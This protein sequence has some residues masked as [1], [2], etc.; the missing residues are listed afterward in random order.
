VSAGLV[1]RALH[2]ATGID[3]GFDPRNVQLVTTN[4]QMGAYDDRAA[5]R[6]VAAWR[7]AAA[8][9]RGAK[10][11]AI[12]RRP[13]LGLGNTTETFTIEGAPATPDS[14]HSVDYTEVSPEYFGVMGIP[15][16]RGR[17]FGRA[18]TGR[19]PSATR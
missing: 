7:D 16:T 6:L 8:S 17:G 4:L 5:H 12:T 3:P 13:P 19:P 1:V 2:R 14:A 10:A 9:L 18:T 11:V 15:V